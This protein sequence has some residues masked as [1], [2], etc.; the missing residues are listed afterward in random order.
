MDQST[1]RKAWTRVQAGIR[2]LAGTRVLAGIRERLGTR[3]LAG[4]RL[5][6]GPEYREGSA[7]VLGLDYQPGPEYRWDTRIARIPLSSWSP[8]ALQILGSDPESHGS[9][10]LKYSDPQ[11][12]K[13]R[14]LPTLHNTSV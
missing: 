10:K 4:I 12:L 6:P 9:S 8:R 1:D 14:I 2:E 11:I 13:S 7:N 3:L 5:A